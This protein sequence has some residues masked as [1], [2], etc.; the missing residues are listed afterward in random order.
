MPKIY[1][2][3][4]TRSYITALKVL[5]NTFVAYSTVQNGI[6]FLDF[7]E[8]NITKN[9]VNRNLNSNT[10]AVAF[11]PNS[12]MFAFV[13]NKTIYIIDIQ[14]KK[15]IQNISTDDEIV[16]IL[17][18]DPSSTY[19]LAGTKS[20]RV[21]QYKYDKT[22]ILSRLCSFPHDRDSIYLKFKEDE[23]YVSSFAFFNSTVACSGYGGAIFIMDLHSQANKN[24]ITH[25]R[26]RIDALCFIDENTLLSGNSDGTLDVT[27]LDNT[28]AYK[29]ISTPLS[30]IKHIV[31]LPNPDYAMV[32]GNTNIISIIDMRRAKIM[33]SKYAE[34][35]AN[36]ISMDILNGETI[37]VA[38]D[39]KK[40]VY[41]ELPS[42]DKLKSF[43][44]HNSF[45]KAYKLIQDE[46]M[47]KGS[48]EHKLLEE[49]FDTKYKE[50]TK[51]LINQHK[52][53]AAQILDPF[54]KVKSKQQEIRNL[55]I[56]FDNFRRFHGL[57]L[58]KKYALAYAMCSKYEPLKQTVQYKKMEQVFKLAF[59][60]A[61][62]QVIQGNTYGAKALL[63]EYAT[64]ISKKPIINLILT[65]NRE[66]TEF[67]QAV[68]DKD[69]LRIN[70][71]IDANV[72]FSQIPN[73][74]A[75]NE[76]VQDKLQNIK[77]SIKSGEIIIAKKLLFSLEKVPHVSDEVQLL[78]LECKHM[79]ILK[80]AYKNDNFKSCYQVLDSHK[81]LKTTELGILLEKHWSKLMRTCE[82]FALK[83]NIKD[84]KQT[85]GELIHITSRQSKIGDLIRVSFHVKINTLIS[86]S[87]FNGAEQI[88]YT[89]IDIFGLDSEIGH[90]MKTF[91]KSSSI[92]LAFTQTER[93]ARNSWV[94][95]PVIMK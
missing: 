49:K 11:S 9:V 15:T 39:N 24:I 41:L 90:I 60:N 50:A 93:P 77:F 18:F 66:F 47:L 72:L 68:K 20:G 83:G 88:I 63:H 7:E 71:L 54:K 27:P 16:D 35:N 91:E 10:T 74:I 70:K 26:S 30:T 12:E 34:F 17:S 3:Q 1:E 78:N 25:R 79:L 6:V 28:K 92:K 87:K 2:C 61:Q 44:L 69:Y 36:I 64:V 86:S 4:T 8:C 95:S 55:F 59:A 58:E 75:L 57:F 62:R 43:I 82:E 73:Y 37:V 42:I 84:I 19:I 40:I 53:A 29:T 22:A 14:T 32:S 52:T 48:L 31:V 80:K 46:P 33:H 13:N 56:A 85:L 94:N 67:L 45:E 51:E 65:Q 38:L 5:D 76:E 23:N 81:S 21:L 89:Y